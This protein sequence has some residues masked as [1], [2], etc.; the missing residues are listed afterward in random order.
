MA[1]APH[2]AEAETVAYQG[3]VWTDG[4]GYA[5]VK[6][7]SDAAL[8]TPTE[9]ELRDLD[10]PS[11]A[12]ITSE[13]DQGRFTVAT[14]EPHVKIAWRITGRCAASASNSDDSRRP[15]NQRRV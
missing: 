2:P 7:P 4:R 6:L 1:H 3:E 10:P 12:R 15:P 14:A 9:Y 8:V 11:T 5:T 13:L